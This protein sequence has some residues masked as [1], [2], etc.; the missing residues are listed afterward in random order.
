M[1]DL[2]HLHV[3]LLEVVEQSIHKTSTCARMVFDCMCTHAIID[4][5]SYAN[6][7][8]SILIRI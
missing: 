4:F 7:H 8:L 6:T 1:C 2:I 3:C 5:H